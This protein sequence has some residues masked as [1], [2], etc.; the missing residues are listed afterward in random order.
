MDPIYHSTSYFLSSPTQEIAT[1]FD[2]EGDSLVSP[3]EIPWAQPGKELTFENSEKSKTRSS[4]DL[5]LEIAKLT[6]QLYHIKQQIQA[7]TFTVIKLSAKLGCQAP[8][9]K[10]TIDLSSSPLSKSQLVLKKL[11]VINT[12][13]THPTS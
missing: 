1:V 10:L 13:Q 3:S 11:P 7:S 8:P 6:E 2:L 12:Q 9:Q 5:N 4:A